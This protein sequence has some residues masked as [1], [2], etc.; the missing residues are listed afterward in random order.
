VAPLAT[1]QISSWN[2][3]V[4]GSSNTRGKIKSGKIHMLK[5]C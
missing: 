3:E 1:E 4:Q 5:E 2:S